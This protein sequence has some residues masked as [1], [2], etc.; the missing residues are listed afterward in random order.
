MF[1]YVREYR[2][3]RQSQHKYTHRQMTPYKISA[4]PA[5]SCIQGPRHRCGQVPISQCTS[6][7]L[8]DSPS[9]RGRLTQKI[10]R[11]RMLKAP[12]VRR[13]HTDALD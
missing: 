13:E 7:Q 9:C 11:R 4:N 12:V 10:K 5:L 8:P 2:M 6:E 3:L 1:Q